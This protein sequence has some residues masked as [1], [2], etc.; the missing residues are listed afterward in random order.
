MYLLAHPLLMYLTTHSLHLICGLILL[1]C[2]NYMHVCHHYNYLEDTYQN[3]EELPSIYSRNWPHP[4][5]NHDELQ[6][7]VYSYVYNVLA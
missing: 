1:V 3:D 4:D 2:G 5:E 7:Q 6:G